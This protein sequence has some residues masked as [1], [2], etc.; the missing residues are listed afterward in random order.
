[1]TFGCF[2]WFYIIEKLYTCRKIKNCVNFISFICAIFGAQ[3]FLNT[4]NLYTTDMISKQNLFEP[5]WL[6]VSFT[7]VSCECYQGY[8]SFVCS[9]QDD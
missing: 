5:V 3:N 4:P 8:V 6:F 1:M 2:Y 9:A 7:F